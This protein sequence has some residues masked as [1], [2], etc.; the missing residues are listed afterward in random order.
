MGNSHPYGHSH[1]HSHSHSFSRQHSHQYSG[2]Q[3]GH[4]RTR[5]HR[6]ARANGEFQGQRP[7]ARGMDTKGR[8]VLPL[9][10][11]LCLRAVRGRGGVFTRYPRAQAAQIYARTFQQ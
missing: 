10:S 6:I 8:A 4:S 3:Y 1:S 9:C 11:P 7:A 5:R 2:D